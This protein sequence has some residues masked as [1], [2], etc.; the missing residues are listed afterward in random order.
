MS[1]RFYTFEFYSA[2]YDLFLQTQTLSQQSVYD[3]VIVQDAQE[4]TYYISFLGLLRYIHRTLLLMTPGSHLVAS[5]NHCW[6]PQSL[7]GQ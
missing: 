4:M 5:V 3:E 6:A 7:S 1:S 2:F